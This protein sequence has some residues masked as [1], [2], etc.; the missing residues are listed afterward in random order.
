MTEKET[1]Q[2]K[3]GQSNPE[4]SSLSQNQ[5]RVIQSLLAAETITAAIGEAGV[6]RSTFYRWLKEPAF[7]ER[8]ST[9]RK[10]LY[11][12]GMDTLRAAACTAAR[13]LV[14]LLDTRDLRVRR[15]AAKD[16]LSLTVQDMEIRE[17]LE[18][19]RELEGVAGNGDGRE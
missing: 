4:K 1:K 18:R 9:E 13:V 5:E 16:V 10:S 2:N 19:V 6:S 12:A 3:T 7:K 11:D 8:L 17:L 15:L 14:E